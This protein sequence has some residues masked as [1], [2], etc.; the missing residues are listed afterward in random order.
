MFLTSRQ[1]AEA[2]D[3]IMGVISGSPQ[4]LPD[5]DDTPT[6]LDLTWVEQTMTIDAIDKTAKEATEANPGW[7]LL[8]VGMGSG[9]QTTLTYGWPWPGTRS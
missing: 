4:H 5:E 3:A 1:A 7:R 2:Y 6:H 9:G 8:H